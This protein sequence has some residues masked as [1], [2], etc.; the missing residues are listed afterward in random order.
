VWNFH[1]AIALKID[2][3]HN[4]QADRA[5]A[6]A[7]SKGREQRKAE[8]PQA[9]KEY[10][11]AQH[12]I[13]SAR[14]GF[15]TAPGQR[16]SVVRARLASLDVFAIIVMVD[17]NSMTL[18]IGSTHSRCFWLPR[19]RRR[20]LANDEIKPMRVQVSSL[21]AARQRRAKTGLSSCQNTFSTG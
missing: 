12:S 17:P 1:T 20:A 13:W 19:T 6:E 10:W 2:L 7:I 8:A 15:G 16:Q 21:C 3:P 4:T 9:M 11:A 5:R 14:S 18:C